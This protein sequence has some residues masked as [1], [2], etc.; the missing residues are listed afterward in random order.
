MYFNQYDQSGE[1]FD[2]FGFPGWPQQDYFEPPPFGPPP[3]AGPGFPPP[4]FSPPIP[5]WQSGSRGIRSCLFSNT[6]IWLINGN[7]FWFYPMNVG[8][9][10]IFGF[11]WRRR[12]GWTRHVIN[13]NEIRSYQCF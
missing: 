3:A 10:F 2:Q 8:R 11:R 9:Q 1:S 7:S 13:R 6:Y 4:G 5:A 12:T